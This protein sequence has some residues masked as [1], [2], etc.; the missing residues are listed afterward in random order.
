MASKSCLVTTS[1]AG[2]AP[3]P[4]PVDWRRRLADRLVAQQTFVPG[5]GPVW[6][7]GGGAPGDAARATALAVAAIAL[8]SP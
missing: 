5:V 3:P 8:V 4:F 6:L 1:A 7:P 2:G